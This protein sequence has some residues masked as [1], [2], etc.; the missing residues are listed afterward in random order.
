M[1]EFGVGA[2]L[3]GGLVLGKCNYSFSCFSQNP[4]TLQ[5]VTSF[6]NGPNHINYSD[7]LAS[8]SIFYPKDV[9]L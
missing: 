4:H 7:L 1:D 5:R 9:Q 2:V 6:F 3:Q 8:I